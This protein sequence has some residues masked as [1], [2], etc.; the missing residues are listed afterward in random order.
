LWEVLRGKVD[1][2]ELVLMDPVHLRYLANFHVDPFSLGA[3]F[4]GV[5][6]LRPDGHATLY[7]DRRLPESVQLAHVDRRDVIPWYDGQTPGR[8]PRR[9]ALRS[10]VE[11]HGGRVHDDLGDALAPTVISEITNLRR[12]KDADEIE[13]L[14]SCMRATEVGH[15]RAR[16]NLRAGMTELEVYEVIF[17]ACSAAAGRPIITYGDFA[18]SPGPGRRGGPPTSQRLH[19][20]DTFILD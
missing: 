19:E 17:A 13:V 16:S 6:V 10:A 11:A 18:V 15:E 3:D 20:G 12:R 14:K 9:L 5:L 4:G 7:H 8:G 2:A 1:V